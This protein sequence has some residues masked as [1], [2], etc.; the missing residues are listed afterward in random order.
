M[1]NLQKVTIQYCEQ[2]DRIRLTGEVENAAPVVIWLTQRLLQRVLQALLKHDQSEGGLHSHHH[3]F[4]SFAQQAATAELEQTPQVSVQPAV[5]S[6][7]WLVNS[8]DL[9]NSEQRVE[10]TFRGSDDQQVRLLLN[11]MLLRQWLAIIYGLYLKADWPLDVW[12]DWIGG[13]A[14]ATNSQQAVRMH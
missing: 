6:S 14:S 5:E 2:E 3:I 4:Q 9:A 13:N 7:V 11:E 1:Q 8:V 12:P 10:L